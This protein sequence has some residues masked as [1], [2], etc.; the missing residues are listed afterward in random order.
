MH[1]FTIPAVWTNRQHKWTGHDMVGAPNHRQSGGWIYADAN[2]T[3]L[4]HNVVEGRGCSVNGNLD[5][6]GASNEDD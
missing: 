5:G 2:F 4:N 3:E 1:V 6:N